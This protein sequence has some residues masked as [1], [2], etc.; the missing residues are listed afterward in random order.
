MK[1]GILGTGNIGKTLISRLSAAGHEVKAA[2]SRGPETIGADVPASGG[3]AVTAA[4][5]V[6]DV[7]A[8]ILSL[9]FDRIPQVTP[10]IAP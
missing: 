5:A 8:V 6:V 7:D 4:E 1:I 3:R 2:N 10:L 9:P